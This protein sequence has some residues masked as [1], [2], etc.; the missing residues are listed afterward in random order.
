MAKLVIDLTSVINQLETQKAAIE[1]ALEALRG[2]APRRGRKP[3]PQKKVAAKK[4]IK[5][6]VISEEGRAKL[7]EAMKKR[8][9]A[10]QAKPTKKRAPK[11]ATKK[12]TKKTTPEAAA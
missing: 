7:A 8:W 9:A 11:K 2:G 1:R 10:K 12:A 6:S 3:G 5:R 4:T